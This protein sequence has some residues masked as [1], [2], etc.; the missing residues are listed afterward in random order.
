MMSSY[1]QV[2]GRWYLQTSRQV[3]NAAAAAQ[4]AKNL[5]VGMGLTWQD[6]ASNGG[7][8]MGLAPDDDD[9]DDVVVVVVVVLGCGQNLLP[10]LFGWQAALLEAEQ[11]NEPVDGG[12]LGM[13]AAQVPPGAGAGR[14]LNESMVTSSGI[15]IWVVWKY[16]FPQIP[17]P[18]LIIFTIKHNMCIYIYVYIYIILVYKIYNHVGV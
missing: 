9:D 18:M 5:K 1:V 16:A 11:G 7:G 13:A 4:P 12:L 6:E 17:N 3:T 2:L 15:S 10:W 8:P 14:H